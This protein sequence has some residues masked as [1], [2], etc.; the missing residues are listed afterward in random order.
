MVD[1]LGIVGVMLVASIMI[2][3]HDCG[4][5]IAHHHADNELGE[6]VGNLTGNRCQTMIT[7]RLTIGIQWLLIDTLNQPNRHA[8]VGGTKSILSLANGD[9]SGPTHS[10]QIISTLVY[11]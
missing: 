9:M 3:Y 10:L 8:Q 1:R 6:F 7:C 11:C 4:A 2:S 5:S